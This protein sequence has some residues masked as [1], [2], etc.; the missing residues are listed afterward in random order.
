MRR[1]EQL[2]PVAEEIECLADVLRP[3]ERVSDLGAA[4]RYEVVHRVRAVLGHAE[5]T[6]IR[7]EEVHLGRRLGLRCQLEHDPDP[8]D[9][10]FLAG[11]GDV[12]GRGDE[13]G[14]GK[15]YGLAEPAIHVGTR[16]G[17]KER[18]ELVVRPA[19]H[20]RA[21]EQV[22]RHRF[23]EKA[24]R[25]NH[26]TAARRHVLVRRD[27]ANTAE[28]VSVGVGV[29]DRSDR[30]RPEGGVGQ[31][32]ARPGAVLARERIDDDPALR[33]GDECEARDVVTACLPDAGRNLEETVFVVELGLAPQ[34]RM[35]GVGDLV[36][37]EE[38]IAVHVPH[39]K[40]RRGGDATVGNLGDEAAGRALVVRSVEVDH[41]RPVCVCRV[42]GCGFARGVDGHGVESD[43]SA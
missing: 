24:D 7:E 4:D 5:P 11:M 34:T 19:Q 16:P 23:V 2:G 38:A 30:S 21:G 25:R 27:A 13:T 43:N 28:V 15:R 17:G 37:A 12:L 1:E 36:G 41:G 29:D 31:V 9:D 20:R 42:L 18:T 22:L 40:A 6:V 39:H 35:N 32:Q 14:S 33:P 8:V 3:R 10:Q 26:P